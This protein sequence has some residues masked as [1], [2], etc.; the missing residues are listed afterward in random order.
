M[1]L[2]KTSVWQFSDNLAIN[3]PTSAALNSIPFQPGGGALPG[4]PFI[5]EPEIESAPLYYNS[6]TPEAEQSE[7]EIVEITENSPEIMAE[8][9]SEKD[10]EDR[11]QG[12]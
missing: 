12:F 8:T 10:E 9:A 5:Q 4:F 7:P 6:I 2:A 11:E 1:P 3:R